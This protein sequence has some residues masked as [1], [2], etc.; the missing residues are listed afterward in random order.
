MSVHLG[1]IGALSQSNSTL[2][3]PGH[4]G[5]NVFDRNDPLYGCDTINTC[6]FGVCQGCWNDIQNTQKTDS[7]EE[8]AV[9]V[10]KCDQP[11]GTISRYNDSYYCE[12]K[13]V[14]ASPGIDGAVELTLSYNVRGDGSLGPLQEPNSSHLIVG[15]TSL[16]SSKVTLIVNDRF[17]KMGDLL[18][19]V[20]EHLVNSLLVDHVGFI[21]GKFG[22]STANLLIPGSQI[23]V[24][25]T[26][27]S[28]PVCSNNHARVVSN[29]SGGGYSS[30][31]ICNRCRRLQR[32]S[33][34]F[35]A[36]CHDDF[37]FSCEPQSRG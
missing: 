10:V 18:F 4:E 17:Q 8:D 3:W 26:N 13:Q 2:L 7:S 6:Q 5:D 31:F 12:I 16:S 22:Y 28:V 19:V 34:W 29:Y 9:T 30:G 1:D 14:S 27:H 32:G 24:A 23:V 21:F 37:C 36:S 15:S 11:T 20:P 25:E 35:C 33:R